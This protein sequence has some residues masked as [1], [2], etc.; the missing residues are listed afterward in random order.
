M[1]CIRF[2]ADEIVANLLAC[3]YLTE[4]QRISLS[5]IRN[6]CRELDQVLP[7]YVFFEM[8]PEDIARAA[9]IY[10]DY[11][12]W[13]S[14]RQTLRLKENGIYPDRERV[15]ALFSSYLA[16]AIADFTDYF[17]ETQLSGKKDQ[18]FYDWMV[19]RLPA[20]SC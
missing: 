2:D 10:S 1:C 7:G 14:T 19:E 18:S 16:E 5:D 8:M 3:K 12:I 20:L 9:I 6:Y 15:N 4:R 17:V 11:C 13:D